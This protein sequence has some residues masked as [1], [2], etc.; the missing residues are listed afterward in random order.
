MAGWRSALW[1]TFNETY[2]L[3][4]CTD[5]AA[6][7]LLRPKPAS[8]AGG[9]GAEARTYTRGKALIC[10]CSRRGLERSF[11]S[12]V[13]MDAGSLDRARRHYRLLRARER[14]EQLWWVHRLRPV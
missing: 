8:R 11:S 5:D 4:I 13:Q 3:R 7:R 2:L 12:P 9:R 1:G 6:R 14:E 10:A